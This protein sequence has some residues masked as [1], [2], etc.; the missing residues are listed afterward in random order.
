MFRIFDFTNENSITHSSE[1]RLD[2]FVID[3]LPLRSDIEFISRKY[4]ETLAN[5]LRT[6]ILNDISVLQDFLHNSLQVLQNVVLDETGL[7]EAGCKYERI[8]TDLP[9]VTF[10]ALIIRPYKTHH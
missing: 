7:A 1:D 10:C 6:S 8:M 9:M 2:C 4:W 3:L 5:T